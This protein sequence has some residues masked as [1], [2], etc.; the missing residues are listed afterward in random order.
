ME[1]LAAATELVTEREGEKTV[2]GASYV[3]VKVG[4][5][6]EEKGE[7]GKKRTPAEEPS[8]RWKLKE[9]EPDCEWR[10]QRG[11]LPTIPRSA[12]KG[13]DGAGKKGLQQAAAVAATLSSS[14]RPGGRA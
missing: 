1:Y 8:G 4:W 5:S 12:R 3:R 11:E 9:H 6:L 10:E 13:T 14:V 2:T 7:Q